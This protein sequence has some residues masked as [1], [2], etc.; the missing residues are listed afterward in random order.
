MSR[1]NS[2]VLSGGGEMGAMMRAVDWSSTRIGP[3]SDWPQSLRTAVG[4]LLD[5]KFPMYIAWGPDFIQLYNDGYRPI[6]GSKKHPAAL[7]RSTR[8]TFAE[9]WDFIGPMFERVMAGGEPAWLIDQLLPLDRHGYVEEC[10]FTFC[11]SAIRD[12][13]GV[14]GVFVT[15]TET[16]G[17]VLGERRLRVLRDLGTAAT[18]MKASDAVPSAV[19]DVLST[20]PTDIPFAQLYVLD[21]EG[22][23][24][25]AG[26]TGVPADRLAGLSWPLESVLASGRS[27]HISDLAKLTGPLVCE[28]WPEELVEAVVLPIFA[29]DHPIGALVCGISARRR[30]DP[31]Y[32]DFLDLVAGHI[33]SAFANAHAHEQERRRA[34]ALAEID[35]A[36]TAF[37]NNVSH[38]FR[39]PLTLML[40]PLEELLASD[41][42]SNTHRAAVETAHRNALRQLRLVNTL[43]DFSRIEAGRMEAVYEPVHLAS[44]TA[45]LASAFRSAIESAGLS[46]VLAV[47]SFDETVFVDVDM[48]EKIVLNLLSNA[49]KHTFEGRI[50]V[51]LRSIDGAAELEI[52]DTGVGISEQDRPHVFDRFHRVK[53]TRAR[54]HEG[55][56]IGLTLVRELVQLHH[57]T[58]RL[59]SALGEGTRVTVRIPLGRAHLPMER[60]NRSRRADSPALGA[61]PFVYEALRWLPNSESGDLRDNVATPFAAAM[62]G[63]RILVADDNLDLREYLTRLLKPYWT[64]QTVPDGASA[65]EAARSHSP[66]LVL[67]DIMMP[68]LDGFELLRELR[69]D[70][71][72]RDIP[73]VLLSARAGEE[74][75]VEGMA[76]GADDYIVKPFSA[77]ELIA[78]IA[79]RLELARAFNELN[80]L[81]R[82]SPAF[83]TVLRGP[84]H[85]FERINQQYQELTGG[86]PLLGRSIREALP[87]IDGQGFYE[88]LDNVY[89]TGEAYV[90]QEHRILLQ[91]SPD[92]PFEER[93]LNFVYQPLRG[94]DGTVNGI[95]V[96]GVDITDL[97]RAR[98]AAEEAN[99]AKS[100]FMATM[101]HELRTPLNAI[102]GYLELLR[103]GVP[104]PLP[105]LALAHVDRIAS[106]A[107]HLLQIIEE[108]LTFTRLNA[109][110]VTLEPS[111]IEI[112][113]L[114]NEVRAVIEPLAMQKSLG[115]SIRSTECPATLRTDARKLRQ[116]LL[117]LLGNAVK[118]T[119]HGSIELIVDCEDDTISLTVCD[120]GIG[121]PEDQINRL[122]EPFWQADQSHT[123]QWGG[124][125]LGLAIS[126]K[127]AAL[128]GGQIHAISE[129]GRGSRFTLLLPAG[130]AGQ[131]IESER[132]PS[133]TADARRRSSGTP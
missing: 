32:R 8:E 26:Y 4:L 37:F 101:S 126:Q 95:F 77:R 66:D 46:L 23:P 103:L 55:T 64:V 108:L 20:N 91:H 7:G 78:R 1:L 9:I 29:Q 40:G 81:F 34:D 105:E 42:L 106:S 72:T 48:W 114:M 86:R 61:V 2:N 89:R 68:G 102:I 51:R 59:E 63:A 35:R 6:L 96:H 117:N 62:P 104:S 85:I 33:G 56:G 15:V 133:F 75:R 5:S 124:T 44:I 120:T 131:P 18:E 73:V 109:G 128:L 111:T 122:F 36:K 53:D 92:H 129:Y 67:A 39:T 82:L 16:T 13:E 121:I 10:I 28:P 24:R 90:A 19:I 127:M 94:T 22:V 60:I 45:D 50:E 52:R 47:E 74:A 14:G 83:I 25:S 12:G 76:A 100:D 71:R 11:Y 70:P 65:L 112:G 118:F 41:G 116:I 113:E 132:A 43:L 58:I 98:R 54:S 107:R 80:E 130:I 123:R 125:G 84:D 17:R 21:G 38:E 69:A 88:L 57:G 93:F 30:L 79:A 110:S 49:F 99:S 87:D 97:V 3:V 31:D 119:E 27:Y 115:F